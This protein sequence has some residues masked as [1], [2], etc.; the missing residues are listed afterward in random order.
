MSSYRIPG[1]SGK[2]LEVDLGREIV[3][4]RPLDPALAEDY[5]GG[6]GLATR[7]FVDAVDPACDPLGEGNV[8]VLATS[9]LVGMNAPTSCRGHVVFKSPLT[10]VIGSSNCGGT[11][12][13]VFKAAGYDAI[14][15][16]GKARTPVMIDITPDRVEL[17]PADSLWGLDVH[18]TTDRL[19]E[20][21]A[22]KRARVLCIGPAGEHLVRFAALMNDK[23]RA[24]GRSGPGAVWGSKNLK[25][26]RVFG[27]EKTR[28]VD[29]ERYQSGLDQAR[30]LLRA[31]PTTKRLLNDMGTAGLVRLINVIDMLPHRNFQDNLHRQDRLD[32][33]S[34]EALRSRLLVRS[35]ACMRCPLGCQ[36][37]TR[38]GDRTGEGPEYETLVLLGMNCDVYDLE[39]VTLANYQCNEL[40]ID[41]MSCG[42]TLACAM[43]LFERRY[44]TEQ[45]TE[46][47]DLSFGNASVLEELV[48]RIAFRTGIGDQ[49]AE[50]A[51]RLA[52]RYHHP[53]V[54]MTVKGLEI[55]AYDPRASYTQALGY[56]TSPT[57]ACHLRGGYAVSLAFFGGA[58][59]IPRFSLL[60]SPIAIRNLQNIGILQDSLGVCR[61][62]GYAY[63]A[64]PWSR[65]VSG[66]TG[67]DFS[68]HRLEQTADRIAALERV[69]NLEAGVTR[70]DDTLPA[71]FSDESIV[72]GGKERCV[73]KDVIERL[74]SDY[75]ELQGWDSEGRPDRALLH[76][77]KIE[78]LR[79]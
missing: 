40:G 33:A 52:A 4:A 70:D 79:S 44:I 38:V 77:R 56:M 68:T 58:R 42:G 28:V 76:K 69:F 21:G 19:L 5:L 65:M 11:W 8:M 22:G 54:A 61:F 57:G 37:H 72:V 59:E 60:Q 49:L 14:V 6:R 30:F 62:T 29:P 15:I 53:E 26:I 73:P 12:A 67:L 16:R 24:Y 75:Y 34:G 3:R 25:A 64:E 9:P 48:R 50:G 71:R 51:A 39:A 45:D 18:E 46:G 7:L 47:L 31:V 32:G 74:R 78:R 66:A 17:L 23:N 43:E 1:Y 41:T 20:D 36:R 27:Q 13:N 35:G 55:P 10:G 63:S 2:I